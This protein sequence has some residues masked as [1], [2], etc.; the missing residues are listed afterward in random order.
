VIAASAAVADGI[1]F[2]VGAHP[3]SISA[4]MELAR[5][6]RTDAGSLELA[7]FVNVVCHPDPDIAAELVRG[8]L[9]L[10]T[11]WLSKSQRELSAVASQ[12]DMTRHGGAQPDAQDALSR[13][14]VDRFAIV[15]PPE[16]C[17]GRLRE[18]TALGLDRLVVIPS[19][20]ESHGSQHAATA[21]RLLV[22]EVL[23]HVRRLS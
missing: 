1:T 16:I 23:P 17:I 9:A 6:A 3:E 22:D 20:P 15:G 14:V 18:L 12:Y 8:T 10:T 11:R 4:A 21:T 5:R 13:D 7:A 19:L 2:A